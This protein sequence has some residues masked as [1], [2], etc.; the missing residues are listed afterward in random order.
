MMIET[1]KKVIYTIWIL[2]IL[3]VG[4]IYLYRPELFSAERLVEFLTNFQTELLLT[5]TVLTFVR[6]FFLIPSTPFVI[7]G[8]MLFPDML[9]L[10]LFISMGGVLFSTACVYYFSDLI[11]FSGYLEKKFPNGTEQWKSRLQQPQALAIVVGWAFFPLVPTDLISYAGGII[12]MP[13]RYIFIGVLIG[14]LSLNIIYVYF[15]A[16]LYHLLLG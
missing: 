11:G 14:E 12:K 10:V 6:G 5:Y 7:G 8:A 1:G 13:F 2:C 3:S 15:G 16:S 4:V 9:A